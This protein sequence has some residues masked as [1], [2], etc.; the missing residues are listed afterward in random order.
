LRELGSDLGQGY[1]LARPL[2][3]EAAQALL[4]PLLAAVPHAAPHLGSDTVLVAE[5]PVAALH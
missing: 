3:A 1:L 5:A 4:A 2:T